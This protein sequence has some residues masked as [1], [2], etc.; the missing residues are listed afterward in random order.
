MEWITTYEMEWSMRSVLQFMVCII[1]LK[2][3]SNLKIW[4]GNEVDY[5]VKW[6][7]CGW[8]NEMEYGWMSEMEYGWMK[9]DGP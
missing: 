8:M 5:G 3:T 6:M 1:Q 7:K 4:G 2:K 9:W